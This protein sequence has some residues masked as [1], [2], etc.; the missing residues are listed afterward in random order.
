M[1]TARELGFYREAVLEVAKKLWLN[2]NPGSLQV[3]RGFA[4]A[5]DLRV[6]KVKK[7]SARPQLFL[8][9][10]LEIDDDRFD[11][12]NRF[13]IRGRDEVTKALNT[14]AREGVLPNSF[15]RSG[16]RQL[17]QLGRTLG[18]D[19][20]I[21][22]GAP[23]FSGVKATVDRGVREAIKQIDAVLSEQLEEIAVEGWIF[24]FDST[25][26]SFKLRSASG[27]A[28]KCDIQARR[29]DL[30]RAAKTYCSADGVTAPDVRITG[31]VPTLD[32]SRPTVLTDV[33]SIEHLRS[34]GEKLTIRKIG[35]LEALDDGWA[36][37]GSIAPERAALEVVRTLA[38]TIGSL[39]WK[40]D[41]ASEDD[42]SVVLE[43]RSGVIECT[44]VL[45]TNHQLFMCTDNV[46]TDELLE[47]E[48]EFNVDVL[49][50]FL[51]SGVFDG[52]VA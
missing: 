9:R 26:Q 38:P 1:E 31:F 15:P 49:T 37:E 21:V 2:A 8:H 48:V 30:G 40:V 50:D 16:V 23:R 25:A 10:D 39:E 41:V 13:Y 51:R 29:E 5:F 11:E 19:E 27:Q 43:W 52:R 22:V 14:A 20:Q 7:G 32:A 36:G 45:G 47:T 3:P 42:G 17:R 28:I 24:A 44:A 12:W 18:D 34:V 46:E 33:S 6:T 35:L 4:D